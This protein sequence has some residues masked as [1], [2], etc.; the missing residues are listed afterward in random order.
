M[1]DRT[2]IL[3]EDDAPPPL[4]KFSTDRTWVRVAILF[5]AAGIVAIL[6]FCT[7]TFTKPPIPASGQLEELRY[8][9]HPDQGIP[10]ELMKGNCEARGC[11][12]RDTVSGQQPKC[13]YPDDYVN[14]EYVIGSKF[15]YRTEVLMKK[16]G[17]PSGFK[18][19]ISMIVVHVEGV[20]DDVVTVKIEEFIPS[21]EI[22]E[23]SGRWKP[24]LPDH[25]AGRSY[26]A[27]QMDDQC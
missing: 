15:Q 2:P 7:L 19:D 20:N 14:Y 27:S 26:Q 5:A 3:R 18:D 25:E 21:S 11:I 12:W 23:G 6:V 1:D 22:K 4:S 13:F 9:C 24:P 17:Q 10:E 8:D 16:T